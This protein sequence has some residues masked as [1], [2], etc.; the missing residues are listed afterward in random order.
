MAISPKLELA[1]EI[2]AKE[3][4]LESLLKNSDRITAELDKCLNTIKQ[5]MEELDALENIKQNIPTDQDVDE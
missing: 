4:V 2:A 5:T 1:L 3:V